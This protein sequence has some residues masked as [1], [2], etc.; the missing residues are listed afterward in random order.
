MMTERTSDHR[1]KEA[2][3]KFKL[4]HDSSI[5]KSEKIYKVQMIIVTYTKPKILE[6]VT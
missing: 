1:R 4:C 6:V 2:D 3:P 5:R